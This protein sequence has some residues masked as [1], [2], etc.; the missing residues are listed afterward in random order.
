ME[1]LYNELLDTYK[2]KSVNEYEKSANDFREKLKDKDFHFAYDS[3]VPYPSYRNKQFNNIIYKK[4]EFHRNKSEWDPK[5]DYD[6]VVADKCSG[7]FKYTPNQKFIK[8]F[9]F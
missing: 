8:N 5:E 1:N 7:E 2:N 6:S 9:F 3:F 4:E